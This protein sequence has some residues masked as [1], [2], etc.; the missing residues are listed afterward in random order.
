LAGLYVFDDCRPVIAVIGVAQF[1]KQLLKEVGSGFFTQPFEKLEI[2][3]CP[4]A[5]GKGVFEI[6]EGFLFCGHGVLLSY[7]Y[8]ACY[9]SSI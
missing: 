8:E 2:Q 6:D 7:E 4:A 5:V 3:V 1:P 9:A